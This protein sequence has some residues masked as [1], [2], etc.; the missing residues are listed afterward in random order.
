MKSPAAAAPRRRSISGQGVSRS[1]REMAQKS[2]PR[3]APMRAAAACS[4][5]TPGTTE[6]AMRFH[7]GLSSASSSSKTRAARA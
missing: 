4:A 6:S 5:D 1:E 7:S 2:W 3:G